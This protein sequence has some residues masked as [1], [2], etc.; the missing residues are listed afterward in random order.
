MKRSIK[1]DFIVRVI[2]KLNVILVIC[3]LY[4]VCL[5]I[6]ILEI[7]VVIVNLEIVNKII[8]WGLGY[9]KYG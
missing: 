1:Y 7:K 5:E 2:M 8:K 6:G 4:N 9:K 3:Y